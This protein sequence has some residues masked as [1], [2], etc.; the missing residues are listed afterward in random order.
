MLRS[1]FL[2]GL[3]PKSVGMC[4][5]YSCFQSPWPL[6]KSYLKVILG[7]LKKYKD[8]I[9]NDYNV[10]GWKVLE[11]WFSSLP[12]SSKSTRFPFIWSTVFIARICLF[13]HFGFYYSNYEGAFGGASGG[14]SLRSPIL[15]VSLNLFNVEK[16]KKVEKYRHFYSP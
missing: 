10:H 7:L 12:I 5:N 9:P 6:F 8:V 4:E 16:S 14:R 2:F 1:S 3:P 15:S 11:K 13:I